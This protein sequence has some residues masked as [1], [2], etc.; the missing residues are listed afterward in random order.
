MPSAVSTVPTPLQSAV[1]NQVIPHT[2]QTCSYLKSAAIAVARPASTECLLQRGRRPICKASCTTV[3]S[4]Q[5]ISCRCTALPATRQAPTTR[6]RNKA[7]LH[8]F[9][10]RF[11][12]ISYSISYSMA[13]SMAYSM[14]RGIA[15][16]HLSVLYS[17]IIFD[18]KF[19]WFS[20]RRLNCLVVHDHDWYIIFFV[21]VLKSIS[22]TESC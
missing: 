19:E 16:S 21:Y 7:D 8:S 17:S 11:H 10:C 20:C 18:L 2:V 4:L 15:I 6:P 14:L 9:S 12:G 22:F 3:Q 5:Q 1:S 13:Y